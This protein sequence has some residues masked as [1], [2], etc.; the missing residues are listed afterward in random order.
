MTDEDFARADLGSSSA[1]EIQ[2]FV[3]ASALDPRF[4]ERPCY[5]EPQR[6]GERP[7][8]L[9]RE[10]LRE[11]GKAG[12]AKLVIRTRQSLACLVPR[13]DVLLLEILR[14]ADEVRD[15]GELSLPPASMARERKAELELA[16]KLVLQMSSPLRLEKYEDDWKTKVQA[17]LEE[18][19]RR[20]STA[21]HGHSPAPT[22]VADLVS[23]LRR[24]LATHEPGGARQNGGADHSRRRASPAS[25]DG[26]AARTKPARAR[27][28]RSRKAA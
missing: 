21:A 7:Y 14:F 26:G 15:P 11:T 4:F 8:A 20:G 16:K 2:D 19:T 23:A 5:L 22:R 17:V 18:K 28:K 25:S 1:I 9:L 24:S 13:G 6:G 12:I 3:D 10:A 27:A